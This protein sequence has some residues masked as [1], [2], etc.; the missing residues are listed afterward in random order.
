M[1][2]VIRRS[3]KVFWR[4][5]AL[6][7][8]AV[9]VAVQLGRVFSPQLAEQKDFFENWLSNMLGA[10]V[11]MGTV[12]ANWTGLLPK[13]QVSELS[14][15]VDDVSD[16]EPLIAQRALIQL[17]LSETFWQRQLIWKQLEL[18]GVK[19]VLR[20]DA[21]GTWSLPGL[22]LRDPNAEKANWLA[23]FDPLNMLLRSG[24]AELTDNQISLQ[25][26]DGRISH[27]NLPEILLENDSTDFH[28]I[29]ADLD[30]DGIDQSLHFIAE[31]LGN[32]RKRDFIG[33]GY[34]AMQEF[35]VGRVLQAM[36]HD[37][38]ETALVL[39]KQGE[40]LLDLE[41]WLNWK[42]NN[43]IELTG[44]L[45][46]RSDNAELET[47][48]RLPEQVTTEF[49]GQ[50]NSAS[51]WRL[52]VPVFTSEWA[53]ATLVDQA[54]KL[55]YTHAG[56]QVYMPQLP[57]AA[58]WQAVKYANVLQGE[59]AERVNNILDTLNPQG[60]LR[61][62]KVV[63]PTDNWRALSI[64]AAADNLTVDSWRGAPALTQVSGYISSG[65]MQGS[66]ALDSSDGFSMY[67]P[68]VYA[69][70]MAFQQAHG[71]VGWRL[72]PDEN[73]VYVYSSHLSLV[74]DDGEVDGVF[75]LYLPW[76]RGTAPS[77]L[78]LQIGVTNSLARYHKKYVPMILPDSLLSWLDKSIVAGKV[79]QAGFFYRGRL[80]GEPAER[81]IQVYVDVDNG[82]LKF[83]PDW[84]EIT[85]IRGQLTVDNGTVTA[86]VD[87]G[88]I[89][90]T[91]LSEGRIAVVPNPRGEKALLRV[92]SQ[93][94]GPAADGFNLVRNHVLPM[95]G[96]DDNIL[97]RWAMQGQMRG[98]IDLSVPL[99]AGEPGHRQNI[100]VQLT[101]A[102]LAMPELDLVFDNLA[103]ELRYTNT[104]GLQADNLS[105]SL[106]GQA[107][108]GNIESK[109][110]AKGSTKQD[111][112]VTVTGTF[113]P[114]QLAEWTLRPELLF[115]QGDVPLKT[116]VRVPGHKAEGNADVLVN[117]FSNLKGVAVNLPGRLAKPAS[118]R[119][120]LA[121]DIPV[122]GSRIDYQFSYGDY[123]KGHFLQREGVLEKGVLAFNQPVNLP[124][125][126]QILFTGELATVDLAELQALQHTY[127]D[128]SARIDT[129]KRLKQVD[130]AKL[131]GAEPDAE[132]GSVV[133]PPL[134]QALDLRLGRVVLKDLEL[135][136]LNVSGEAVDRGWR[137]QLQNTMLAG[138][139]AWLADRPLEVD[140]DY[141]RFPAPVSAASSEEPIAAGAVADA[142]ETPQE[143]PARDP[144]ADVDM[145]SLTDMNFSTQEFRIGDEDYGSW[146]FQ[147]RNHSQPGSEEVLITHILAKL[148]ATEIVSLPDQPDGASFVWRKNESGM[149]SDFQGRFVVSG[150]QNLLVA[151][152]QPRLMESKKA[153]FDASWHW[154]GSPA[155]ISLLGLEGSL[156]VNIEEGQFIK[157]TDTNANSL[158]RLFG[159]F[160]F[161][162]WA[163][164]LKLDFSDLYSEGM[165][166]DTVKGQLMFNRGLVQ[167][168]QPVVAKTPSSRLQLGGAIDLINETLDTRLVATLPVGG[169]LTLISALAGGLPMA[170]G[171]YVA[172][173]LFEK[174]VEK[175]ASLSYSLS[176]NWNDPEVRFEKLF[177]DK[178]AKEASRD[179]ATKAEALREEAQ[180]SQPTAPTT[181]DN[182]S[183]ES[184]A[185][186]ATEP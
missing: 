97:K 57:L 81:A 75:K 21:E 88:Q 28:R 125:D 124:V 2:R 61:A 9:A 105:A 53:G 86:A 179:S 5:C 128:Y 114:E 136:N 160:N 76:K 111:M 11:S 92:E 99:H 74:D 20:Q 69:D 168:S 138:D 115:L 133:S 65:L 126:P 63:V 146:S 33:R 35:P 127:A 176:G 96:S 19:L 58:W 64:T 82:R 170:A 52:D 141:L 24:R 78:T 165:A 45:S 123:V 26:A 14:I 117:V 44:R 167:I 161:D 32:P 59:R 152:K 147:L 55:S 13:I 166:F 12:S 119:V 34:V 153:V 135:E 155:A 169:N 102:N 137:L 159:L 31:G 110:T 130:T 22:P 91:E 183:S 132:P 25:F 156:Q 93:L 113:L 149:H 106:W 16:P 41:V 79:K 157:G 120:P 42:K 181:D 8:I 30:V 104:G 162:S 143:K 38:S 90:N 17:D 83:H 121:V 175:V 108:T 180:D 177:D 36:P 101:E 87:R 23:D 145:A 51:N 43:P 3:V 151:W 182:L 140:L 49:A 107:L 7:I 154:Q 50:W 118:T 66:I 184:A 60:T 139:V 89:F 6:L 54:L 4:A 158:L 150:M 98:S 73:S 15:R 68:K 84:P 173:K 39:K 47:G 27:L 37:T 186:P 56:L 94:N 144:L 178:A 131:A 77:D 70:P 171:V 164:R 40:A 95:T 48:L 112:A 163:R 71:T 148:R 134:P 80:K 72:R 122:N 10:Q 18:Q 142:P 172:S 116:V 103:A 62:L 129:L 29:S 67:Y 85:D 185:P 100:E 46:L 174:Q 109:P 1:S